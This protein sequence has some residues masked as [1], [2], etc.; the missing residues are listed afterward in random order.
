MRTR[1][2]AH[3]TWP[4]VREAI[5]GGAG[6][7]LPVG[8]TEQHGF[9][10]PLA[11]DALLGSALARDVAGAVDMLVA[12][13]VSYGYRSRPLTGGGSGFVGTTSLS[14][15]TLMDLVE[16]VLREFLRHGFTRLVVLNWHMENQNFIYE[17][18]W[19]AVEQRADPSARVMVLETPFQDLPDDLR[20]MMWPE[21]FPGWGVEHAARFETSLMLHVHPE[22]VL[23]ERAVDDRAERL[24]WWDVVPTPPDM[25][26][27]SGTL[28]TVEGAT[29]EKGR[30]AWEAI[31]AQTTAAVREE[32]PAP[33]AGRDGVR[34][35][36]G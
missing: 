19:L 7:I 23:A 35:R 25:V 27:A 22:L 12:P 17:S 20:A 11:T 28:W 14:A 5:D 31:V 29:A 10:L 2:L 4:E 6:V 21:G 16:D 13:A 9:H 26:P 32:L 3:L 15:R 30:L 8:A 34:T 33:V 18:A 36:V 24:P 1:E